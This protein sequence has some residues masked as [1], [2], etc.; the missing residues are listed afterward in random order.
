[1]RKRLLLFISVFVV[2]VSN[3]QYRTNA[4]QLIMTNEDSLNAGISKNKTVLSGYGSASYQRDFNL[5][6][7][8]ATLERVV[9]FVGHQFNP[10]ISVFTE[11]EIE[12][13]KVEGGEPGGEIALE[14]AFLKF[15]LNPRQYLI[16]GLIIPRI[17]LLNENH[18][19]VN[20]NGVERPLVEQLVIPATWRELGIGFYGTA[21]R[22]PLNYSVALVNGLNSEG[23]EHGSGIREGR[24]EGRNATANN[25]AVTASLQYS[26]SNFKFQVSGY[27]G[28]TVGLP[29][30][31]AD[32]LGLNSGA[33]GTPLYLG[34]ANMQYANNGFSAKVLGAYI[35]YPDAEKIN[36]AYAKNI[37]KGMYGAYAE[38]GYDWLYRK[39]K[40]AQLITFARAEM[41]DLNASIPAPPKAIY[42]GTEKQTHII[43][44]FSY[45]PI[46]NVVIKADVRLLHTGAQNPDLVINPAPNALPY[47]QSN[48]FFNLGIGYSF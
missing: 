35:A 3:A 20:F 39:Q 15:N 33:F 12:N 9:L 29:K 6:Q 1:M 34:E 16:A 8:T 5:K 28:G 31:S 47:Q 36:T 30:T 2:F 18:L 27:M 43:A 19:P 22:L 42:D 26:V 44:G 7:S 40:K 38:F 48:Q 41:F 14:Q 24:A 37:A 45:L 13:A 11:M 21:N 17:G 4:Q 10:K 32:S 25:L 46:P 23:F